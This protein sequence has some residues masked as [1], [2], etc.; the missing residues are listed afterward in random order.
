MT[1]EERQLLEITARTALS[2]KQDI[3]DR[4]AGI[5]AVLLAL[6]LS[7]GRTEIALAR[8]KVQADLLKLKGMP[9]TYLNSFVEKAAGK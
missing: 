7:D 1:E 2:L 9:S 8:L 4:V 5:E 6:F 3:G